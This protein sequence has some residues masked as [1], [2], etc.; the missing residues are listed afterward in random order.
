MSTYSL[1]D[2]DYPQLN[3]QARPKHIRDQ[4]RARLNQF[5]GGHF[6]SQN[7]SSILYAHRIDSDTHAQNV[8]LIYW[9]APGRTKPTFEEAVRALAK[10]GKEAKKGMEFGPS[11]TNHWFKVTIHIPPEWAEYERVQCKWLRR[12]QSIR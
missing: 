9:S 5:E 8:K 10:D 12:R 1:K 7:L 2:A 3:F 6:S 4:T 11:W